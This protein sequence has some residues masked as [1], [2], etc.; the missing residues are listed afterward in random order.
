[1][2]WRVVKVTRTMIH[3]TDL[4]N[5][6]QWQVSGGDCELSYAAFCMVDLAI[7]KLKIYHTWRKE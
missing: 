2:T 6:M 4:S 7:E 5:K 3:V 1:M